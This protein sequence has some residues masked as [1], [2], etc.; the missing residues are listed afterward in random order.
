MIFAE[1][2][3]QRADDI[4]QAHLVGRDH[5]G[6]TLDHGH[7]ARLADGIPRQV[8]PIKDASACERAPSRGC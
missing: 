7:P 8:R 3:A 6:V 4:V 5:V 1:R 2:R